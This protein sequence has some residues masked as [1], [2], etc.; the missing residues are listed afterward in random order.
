MKKSLVNPNSLLHSS[1]KLEAMRLVVHGAVIRLPATAVFTSL[2]DLSL[3]GMRVEDGDDNLPA[4]LLSRACWPRLQKLHLIDPE[5]H[6][7]LK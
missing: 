7:G 1:M 3:E 2:S 5:L 4:L 6:A